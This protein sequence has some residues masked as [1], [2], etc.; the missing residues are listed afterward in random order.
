MLLA[1]TKE[2]VVFIKFLNLKRSK[3]ECI[4]RNLPWSN[5]NSVEDNFH[6]FVCFLYGI[7][8]NPFSLACMKNSFLI[9]K[10]RNQKCSPM[11]WTGS[12]NIYIEEITVSQE[13]YWTFDSWLSNAK[14]WFC[15][16][17]CLLIINDQHINKIKYVKWIACENIVR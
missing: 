9:R 1:E 14:G 10:K 17:L 6:V 15:Q 12:N 3:K 11:Q 8:K 2:F 4:R 5:C 16:H 13:I 7:K